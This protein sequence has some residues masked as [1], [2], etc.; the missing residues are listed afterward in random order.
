MSK[1][2]E[3]LKQIVETM[4]FSPDVENFMEALGPFYEEVEEEECNEIAVSNG[5]EKI[6]TINEEPSM[7]EM[8]GSYDISDN[9]LTDDGFLFPE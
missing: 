4:N 2:I 5:F 6:T 7:N 1:Y 9:N 3:N 8:L